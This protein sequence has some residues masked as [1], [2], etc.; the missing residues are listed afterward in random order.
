M[1]HQSKY[2]VCFEQCTPSQEQIHHVSRPFH[3]MSRANT[4]C[5]LTNARPVQSKY[6]VSPSE[7]T[8]CL[9]GI[10]PV[11]LCL[12]PFTASPKRIH[13]VPSAFPCMTRGN[14]LCLLSNFL[15]V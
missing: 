15:H 7:F 1:H 5:V 13:H 6:N 10:H 3:C 8:A 4:P 2:I 14:T 12:E 9:E 11:P